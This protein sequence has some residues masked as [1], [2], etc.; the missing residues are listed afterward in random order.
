VL[1]IR[2]IKKIIN[3]H[4]SKNEATKISPIIN[5]ILYKILMLENHLLKKGLKAPFGLSIFLIAEKDD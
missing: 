1:I 4:K 5:K 3:K 2:I